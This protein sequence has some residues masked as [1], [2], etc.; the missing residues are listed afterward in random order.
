MRCDAGAHELQ[1]LGHGEPVQVE[2]VH[3]R[4]ERLLPAAS[5]AAPR[6]SRVERR[7]RARVGRGDGFACLER[8]EPPAGGVRPGEAPIVP[9]VRQSCKREVHRRRSARGRR[10]NVQ[11]LMALVPSPSAAAVVSFPGCG[12]RYFLPHKRALR[13]RTR[14]RGCGSG[15]CRTRSGRFRCAAH[16]QRLR[17]P[18][19]VLVGVRERSLEHFAAVHPSEEVRERREPALRLRRSLGVHGAREPV[20]GPRTAWLA[21][22][23][24]RHATPDQRRPRAELCEDPSVEERSCAVRVARARLEQRE[25]L[26]RRAQD[27][28][29]V[30]LARS[31]QRREVDAARPVAGGSG[32]SR[33]LLR[34]LAEQIVNRARHVP[35]HEIKHAPEHAHVRLGEEVGEH[36]QG[37]VAAR[38]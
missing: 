32:A 24:R 23:P 27:A 35:A 30:Q 21:Q 34:L 26:R 12:G 18:F 28:R 38:G 33:Q 14:R 36:A 10:L 22:Q 5:P 7:E 13:R 15:R 31:E 2:P 19:E 29:H 4:V 8:V 1:R 3:A 17:C 37:P 20:R 25:L 9:A 6:D 16:E 11:P